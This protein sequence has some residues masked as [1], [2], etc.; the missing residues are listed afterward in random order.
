MR[1]TFSPF[2]TLVGYAVRVSSPLNRSFLS[3]VLL[4]LLGSSG[5]LRA[6]G[7]PQ[8]LTVPR[9]VSV[10]TNGALPSAVVTSLAEDPSGFVWIGTASG[11]VRHDGYRFRLYDNRWD[12][13]QGEISVFV[14][15][16]MAARD[17]TI[18]VG[19]DFMGMARYDAASD[20][21][22]PVDLSP[23]V[24]TPF[25]INALAEDSE[26]RI[27]LATDGVGLVARQLDGS[28]LHYRERD[29]QGLPS[30]RIH[31][32]LIDRHG[33]LWV[34]TWQGLVS[35]APGADRFEQID[36]SGVLPRV[37]VT[38]LL[39]ADDGQLWIGT[40]DGQLWR[41][42]VA[43]GV[44][45][46]VLEEESGEIR[47]TVRALLQTD[48]GELWIG[49]TGGIELRDASD[50]TLHYR[51]KHAPN[52][53]Y[54]LAANEVRD[55]M[56][57][58]GGQIWVG[59]FGS[60]V[61]RHNPLNTA[62]HTLDRHAL[63]SGGH[64]FE[65]PNV[66]A[67]TELQ[68]G[69]VLLG[70]TDRG[71]LVLDPQLRPLGTLNDPEGQPMFQGVRITGLAQTVDHAIWI[72][73]DAG[74][75]RRVDE[76]TPLQQFPLE[77]GRVRRLMADALGNLWV[78]AEDGLLRHKPGSDHL[79][80]VLGPA[81][82]T[83]SGDLNA[84]GVDLAG[85]LWVGGDIGL[86]VLD[87]PDGIVRH[88]VADHPA[89]GSNPDV[90]G[91][92]PDA[93]GT[94]WFDTP[95]GLF[96]LHP[97]L[98]GNGKVD[99]ISLQYGAAGRPFGANLLMD[100]AGRL[101]TQDH[102]LDRAAGRLIELG[103]ADGA[104]LGSPWYRAYA[105][106]RTGKLLFGSVNG[107]VVVQPQDYK[108]P[109]YTPPLVITSVQVDGQPVPW[110]SDSA[111][112]HLSPGQRRVAIEF[113]ALDYSAPSNIR[114]R[115]RLL[116]ESDKWTDAG[117]DYRVATYANLAPGKYRF[118]M[119]GSD[120][121][122][123][124]G[125]QTLVVPIVVEAAWWQLWWVRVAGV[126]VFLLAVFTL[127]RQRTRWLRARQRE[128]ERS[129]AARTRELEELSVKLR[130]KSRALK[131]ASLTDPLTGLRNRRFFHENIE[132][133]IGQ[134]LNRT[135]RKWVDDVAN[136][137]P[138]LLFILLD[139][140]HFKQVNDTYGHAAGDAVLVQV[141]ERLRHC[142]P[143]TDCLVR[144]GGEEFLVVVRCAGRESAA[145]MA[146]RALQEVT[147]AVFELPGD[148]R[149]RRT[150]SLGYSIYP[151]Q[152]KFPHQVNWA[153]VLEVADRALYA[154][155]RTGRNGW[156]GII[157]C[158]DEPV[159]PGWLDDLAGEL[160]A[161]RLQLNSSLPID[162]AQHALFNGDDRMNERGRGRGF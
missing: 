20:Q 109:N 26:G 144:W 137:A 19:T 101:W 42:P 84:L 65:A 49:H 75:F 108:Y 6:N 28:L 16:L 159:A 120:R 66:R 78:A 87:D 7:L 143:D 105:K 148:R 130:D 3:L 71:V 127:M 118:E 13:A 104:N 18:W 57:D 99:A 11:V 25:S 52:D 68:D 142:F 47:G 51:L 146:E 134:T 54:S 62:I 46:P 41:M 34:G 79:Q 80:R 24:P 111:V 91:L 138:S 162:D 30:D 119:R 150:C 82:L 140:D 61:Q 77:R 121:H 37:P 90:L 64:A 147:A 12:S 15:T 43:D 114:Y 160:A 14:R 89:R 100:E 106:L 129:V 67:I 31:S 1:A 85:R 97:S 58:R 86:S 56:Q 152:A 88:V 53:P 95:S 55:L 17:G 74:L 76:N 136:E 124:F 59:S 81:G 29:R 92:W 50:G 83:L 158:G 161:E 113:A 126:A 156:L 60:G 153:D 69:R 132:K 48:S 135:E 96:R 9:L 45:Q 145:R 4:V 63:A 70:T 149:V 22:V 21:I 44:P 98:G 93:D 23:E 125:Q 116:G 40:N 27:W 151:L 141:G 139:I 35:L 73:S 2:I 128:L 154:I 102:M 115:Y 39:E 10:G 38:A 33:T 117:A 72:A 122:G 131:E 8:D 155:K 36:A 32:L 94:I 110:V 112:L 123:H 5:L 107:L 133:L 103:P 157:G